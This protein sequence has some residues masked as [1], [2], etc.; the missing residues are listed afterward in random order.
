MRVI[1]ATAVAVLITVMPVPVRFVATAVAALVPPVVRHPG[2][3]GLELQLQLLQRLRC[4]GQV[5]S[6]QAYS[7]YRTSLPASLR[8]HGEG[9]SASVTYVDIFYVLLMLCFTFSYSTCQNFS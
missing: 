5:S 8:L 1:S 7:A 4:A 9:V 3:L 2:E 6:Y